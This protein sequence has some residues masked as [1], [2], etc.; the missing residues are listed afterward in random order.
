MEQVKT[1]ILKPIVVKY[2]EGIHRTTEA[3]GFSK[4]E[5]NEAKM[6]VQEARRHGIHV[7]IRRKTKNDQNVALLNEWKSKLG[8]QK[9]RSPKQRSTKKSN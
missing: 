1:T 5:L 4:A 9:K 2:H 7:D 6:T 3:T 8:P